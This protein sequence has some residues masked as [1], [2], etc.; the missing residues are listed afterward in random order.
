MEDG[1]DGSGSFRC[2]RGRFSAQGN[3]V[4]FWP[5][6]QSGVR[7]IVRQKVQQHALAMLVSP[8]KIS[9]EEKLDILQRFDHPGSGTSWMRNVI[10]SFAA[11][12]HWAGNAG[13]GGHRWK[14]AT[15][16]HLSDGTL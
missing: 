2:M 11:N 12:H 4:G 10:A 6:R 8:I 9:D 7:R 15:A 14:R 16:H 3:Q 1:D 13:D 5:I